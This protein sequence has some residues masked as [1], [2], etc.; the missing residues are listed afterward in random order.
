MS[1]RRQEK[2]KRELLEAE[3]LAE[4]LALPGNSSVAAAMAV[5]LGGAELR[6]RHESSAFLYR[7][8]YPAHLGWA[9]EPANL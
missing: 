2:I 7:F 6:A 1:G 8:V 9:A 4:L 3:R 5:V